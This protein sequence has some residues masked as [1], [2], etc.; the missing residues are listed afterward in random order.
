MKFIVLSAGHGGT[1]PGAVG[2]GYEEHNLAWEFVK[3]VRDYLNN[4]YTGQTI[5]TLE[6]KNSSGN[7]KTNSQYWTKATSGGAYSFHFNAASSASATGTEVLVGNYG[8]SRCTRINNALAKHFKNRGLKSVDTSQYYMLREV[9]FD[10]IA[11]ICFISNSDDMK[12]YQANKSKIVANVGDA[13]ATNE[14]LTKKTTT[15]KTYRYAKQVTECSGYYRS[16]CQITSGSA[17]IWTD[18]NCTKSTGDNLNDRGIKFINSR[19]VKKIEKNGYYWW[20]HE[21]VTT[22]GNKRYYC[23]KRVEI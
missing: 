9:G 3:L 1:D 22:K 23:Y 4:N 15:K 2:N 10:M 20:V 13:I 17:T 6:E 11:E 18:I 21:Y 16:H 19:Y 8:T 7:F 14:G 5:N 12:I